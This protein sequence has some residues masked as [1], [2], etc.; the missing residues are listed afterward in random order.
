[1]GDARELG[2]KQYTRGK[3]ATSFSHVIQAERQF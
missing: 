3:A 1:M 2:A